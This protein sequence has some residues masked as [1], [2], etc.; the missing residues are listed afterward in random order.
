MKKI[1]FIM[2]SM[3]IGGAERVL[4]DILNNFDYSKYE[5]E[6]LLYTN[7]GD[8]LSLVNKNVKVLYV[9][10]PMKRTIFFR[11]RYKL[12]STLRLMGWWEKKHLMKLK[13]LH[14][15]CI[16]SFC[17]GPAHK[18]HTFLLNNAPL[19]VSWIHTDLSLENWGKLFFDKDIKKQELAYNMMNKLVFVSKGAKE[20]FNRTFKIK[21]TIEQKVIYNIVDTEKVCSSATDFVIDKPKN[22]FLFVNSGRLVSQKKQIRLVEAAKILKEKGYAFEIWILGEGPLREKIQ[23]RINH[24]GLNDYV[25]LLGVKANPYPYMKSADSFVLSSSQ[26]GFPI[27]VCEALALGIPVISTHVVG[28]TELLGEDS[29]YGLLVGESIEEIVKGMELMINDKSLRENYALKA[30][31]RSKM[32]NKTITMDK[33]YNV[34]S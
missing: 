19:H 15:D 13:L 3:P 11:I 18:L 34:L 7:D 1:L 32:L 26:E 27:V 10:Q 20:T 29:L 17:Q 31:E 4:V 14:Y 6:L 2:H 12:L 8:M 22:K 25:R 30:L 16:V 24:Y 28:P 5:V 21:D 9:F 23:A 33:I